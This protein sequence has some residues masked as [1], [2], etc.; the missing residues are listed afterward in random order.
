M[1]I[2]GK[3]WEKSE[4]FGEIA[5]MTTK[6]SRFLNEMFEGSVFFHAIVKSSMIKTSMK[7]SAH[8]LIDFFLHGYILNSQFR[9]LLPKNAQNFAD[10]VIK[11]LG[12]SF[13]NFCFSVI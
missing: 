10:C 13:A 4:K 6:S 9:R 7:L 2:W 5:K 1:E 8:K 11:N 3:L 12:K